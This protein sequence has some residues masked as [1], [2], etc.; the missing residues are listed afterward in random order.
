MAKE[1]VLVNQQEILGNQKAILENQAKLNKIVAK[2][3]TIIANQK[4][5]AESS[6]AGSGDCPSSDDRRQPGDDSSGPRGDFAEPTCNPG[7]SDQDSGPLIN[8]RPPGG[9]RPDASPAGCSQRE[10]G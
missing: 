5:P 6:Q 7:Q 10:M 9:R 1:E 8:L 4:N 3:A 2:Q